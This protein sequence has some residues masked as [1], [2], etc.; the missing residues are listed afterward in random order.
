MDRKAGISS[1]LNQPRQASGSC[2]TKRAAQAPAKNA[3]CS[4]AKEMAVV[5]EA[6][7]STERN[8]PDYMTVDEKEMKGT[9]TRVPQFSEIPY[10]A[11]M[12]PNL[13]VEFYSR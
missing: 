8:V 1:P 12:E 10:A 4:S 2:C 9:F 11:Q 5:I 13:V 7:A 6:L 3:A